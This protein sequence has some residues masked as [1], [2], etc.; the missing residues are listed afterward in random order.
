MENIL[1][2]QP[3]ADIAGLKKIVQ[4]EEAAQRQEGDKRPQANGGGQRI[5]ASGQA[6]V[7]MSWEA[8]AASPRTWVVDIL[9]FSS[10]KMFA[11]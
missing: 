1:C 8:N 2:Q 4:L 7:G 10:D 9:L 5:D 6:G 11:C 3:G